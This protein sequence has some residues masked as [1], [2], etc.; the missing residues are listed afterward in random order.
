MPHRPDANRAQAAGSGTGAAASS[1]FSAATARSHA[2]SAEMPKASAAE[3]VLAGSNP[4]L[5]KSGL[6]PVIWPKRTKAF[7]W[8]PQTLGWSPIGAFGLLLVWP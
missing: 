7:R 3:V 2:T 5:S 6:T 4:A 8:S 1:V